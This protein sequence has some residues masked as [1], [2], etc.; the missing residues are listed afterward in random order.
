ME[1]QTGTRVDEYSD[2]LSTAMHPVLLNNDS[3]CWVCRVSESYTAPA[4]PLRKRCEITV[5]R[6]GPNV[7]HLTARASD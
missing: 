7:T 3:L 5:C 2:Y 6:S 1:L 4:H